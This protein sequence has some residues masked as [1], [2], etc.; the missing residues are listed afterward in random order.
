MEAGPW[1]EVVGVVT[2]FTVQPDFDPPDPRL[3]EPMSLAQAPTVLSL[4]VRVRSGFTARF[5]E[6]AASVDPALHLH[7]LQS[8]SD[9]QRDV[10]R[11]VLAL[12]LVIVA[13]TVRVLLLSAAGI[14][15]ML[16]FTV[17]RRRCEIAIRT[18]LGAN[19]RLGG[20]FARAS[21]QLW[22]GCA[23]WARFGD[24]AGPGGG[25]RAFGGQRHC[26]VADRG[27]D[28]DWHWAARG[29]WTCTTW[30]GDPSDGGAAGRVGPKGPRHHLL[31]PCRSQRRQASP[32]VLKGST[33]GI[34]LS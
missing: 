8:A 32:D 26:S 31:C 28:H 34:T 23:G 25:Q 3:Y 2:D 30:V 11:S 7:D 19:T 29:P 12:A 5:R 6:I 4:A 20:I 17:A 9:V 10:Q 24:P 13:L 33:P 14:Y 21:A 18:A 16:S 22:R 27:G 15:A 1:L